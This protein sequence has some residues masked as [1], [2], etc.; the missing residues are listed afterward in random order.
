MSWQE[1]SL[2]QL[3]K[4]PWNYKTD[5]PEF[6]EK[7]KTSIETHGFVVNLIVREMESGFFEV[8][9]GNH[10]LDALI[11]MNIE[12]A[13]CKNLGPV[14]LDEAKLIALETNEIQFPT[15]DLKLGQ[16]LSELKNTMGIERLRSSLTATEAK[17][18][19]LIGLAEYEFKPMEEKIK[20][21]NS[22]V[23]KTLTFHLPGEVADQFSRQIRRLLE[24]LGK[25]VDGPAVGAIE[26]IANHLEQTSDDHFGL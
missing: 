22:S 9:N 25:D 17:I 12:K 3:R 18:R 2:D 10:R 6:L 8:V 26:L 13:M 14:S 5:S 24:L 4:A 19:D 16:I 7:L 15:D 21:G 1:L 20:V 23:F 11:Q